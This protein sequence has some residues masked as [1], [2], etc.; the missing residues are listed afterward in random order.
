M[1]LKCPSNG[2]FKT[3]LS[4]DTDQGSLKNANPQDPIP[5]SQF[6]SE[7]QELACLTIIPGNYAVGSGGS[8]LGECFVMCLFKL[9]QLA[10]I[11]SC[12]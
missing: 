3:K 9:K 2:G 11:K 10:Y 5:Q 8:H 4:T 6:C 1:W 7:A 12:L